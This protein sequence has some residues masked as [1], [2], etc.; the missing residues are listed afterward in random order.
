MWRAPILLLLAPLVLFALLI[1]H[2]SMALG[3]GSRMD[4]LG[5]GVKAIKG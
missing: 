4:P 5:Y 2:L 1:A 3:W